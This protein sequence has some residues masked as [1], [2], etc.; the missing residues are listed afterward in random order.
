MSYFFLKL[1]DTG[2]FNYWFPLEGRQAKAYSV[3]DLKK[4]VY[5]QKTIG[6]KKK[7]ENNWEKW[8]SCCWKII[9][10]VFNSEQALS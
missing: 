7:K 1:E 5:T 2:S 10:I 9:A 3:A 8:G 6:K 4:A